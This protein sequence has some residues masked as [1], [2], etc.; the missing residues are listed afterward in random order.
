MLKP[1]KK[2]DHF[3]LFIFLLICIFVFPSSKA[4]AAINKRLAGDNRYKTAIEISKAGWNKSKNIVL[5]TGDSFPDALSAAPLAKQLD[6]PIL[7]TEKYSI[8]DGLLEE[9]KRLSPEN[10]FIVGGEN[11]ISKNIEDQIISMG[12]EV[13]RLSGDDRY[14]TSIKV[15]KYIDSNFGACKEI[16]V[17]TGADFPDAL[18]IAPIAANKKMPIILT[19][20]NKLSD[21]TKV[22]LSSSNISKC[23]IIGGENVIDN[24]V[25]NSLT[26]A[27][28][29]S[30][31]N[32]YETNIAILNK[33]KED[34]HFNTIYVA[35]GSDFP[36]ALS[37]SALAPKTSSPII[38]T[39]KIP[40]KATKYFIENIFSSISESNILG[41]DK[42]IPE[43]TL[44][45]L[46]P[47]INT[48]GNSIGN[49]YNW[50][51]YTMQG[52][53]IY[54][55]Y[56]YHHKIGLYK[57]NVNDWIE[58]KIS[59]DMVHGNI[60]VL[61]DWIYYLD[62]DNESKICKIKTDGTEKTQLVEAEVDLMLVEGDWI[63]YSTRFDDAKFYK[64]KTDGTQK[65]LISDNYT[66]YF[67][68]TDDWIYYT[69]N[70]TS[71][72]WYYGPIELYRIKKDGT[73]NSKIMKD[74]KDHYFHYINVVG[75]WIYYTYGIDRNHNIYKIKTDGT[76]NTKINSECSH[77]INV[78]GDWIYFQNYNDPSGR[79]YKIKTDG[80]CK[81]RLSVDYA[82][83]FYVVGD[84]IFY[85]GNE[86]F[87]KMRLDGS[88]HQVIY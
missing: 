9:I 76:Q 15:A 80:S 71:E 67:D 22:Y 72:A 37:G 28:R 44:H 42:V 34:F 69:I 16:V 24:S 31:D 11:V 87:Y 61:G 57:T 64:I 6:G 56:L 26:N 52:D 12:I 13:I 58:I 54:Y 21:D 73:Q 39:G 41:G 63:Y 48:I 51:I 43:Q 82:E 45:N 53:W 74:D 55:N 2:F 79:L 86:K 17:A 18:S 19:S 1:Q 49:I 25:L 7:L 85:L 23:Y 66:G 40:N 59:D 60:N 14:K 62:E 78:V 29:I 70:N 83:R 81:T 65:T 38:L 20:K 68:I 5:A 30:G 75:D 35:T 46:F 3:I 77:R 36:D 10:I 88:D 50:G 84:W 47:V 32:R 4:S 33:F 27:E 8:S